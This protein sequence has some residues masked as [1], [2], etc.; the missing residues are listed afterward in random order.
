M[1][2][3]LPLEFH[4]IT[5]RI[6][7]KGY[8]SLVPGLISIILE[9]VWIPFTIPF[10]GSKIWSYCHVSF[11]FLGFPGFRNSLIFSGS[12]I[13]DSSSDM[14]AGSAALGMYWF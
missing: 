12:E 10:T 1:V 3:C 2:S 6:N 11:L 4:G 7:S 9:M 13:C 14:L 5:S 8:H